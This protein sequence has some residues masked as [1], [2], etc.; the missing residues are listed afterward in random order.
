MKPNTRDIWNGILVADP[1]QYQGIR[2]FVV[3]TGGVSTLPV[4]TLHPRAEKIV[5]TRGLMQFTLKSDR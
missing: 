2:Q 4:F 1:T 3:G 5:V